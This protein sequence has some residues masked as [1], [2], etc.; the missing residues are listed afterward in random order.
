[1][2]QYG[3]KFDSFI[4][5]RSLLETSL[6]EKQ[7]EH[8]FKLLDEEYLTKIKPIAK[9][10]LQKFKDHNK[11]SFGLDSGHFV[12]FD[13]EDYNCKL[14]TFDN[15]AYRQQ[16]K[17]DKEILQLFDK[18]CKDVTMYT[19]RLKQSIKTLKLKGLKVEV[20]E[21]EEWTPFSEYQKNMRYWFKQEGRMPSNS[22][23]ILLTINGKVGNSLTPSVDAVKDSDTKKYM[24]LYIQF[25][26]FIKNPSKIIG[27]FDPTYIADICKIC[28]ISSSKL[29]EIVSKNMKS[30]GYTFTLD[31]E[32]FND[33][34]WAKSMS[35]RLGDCYELWY[36]NAD[37]LVYSLSKKKLYWVN[38]EHDE[39]EE[40]YNNYPYDSKEFG[41]I[42]YDNKEDEKN[43]IK[44]LFKKIDKEKKF[45]I[46]N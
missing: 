33:P 15:Y 32:Y 8:L 17:S 3:H 21:S 14:V 6:Q 26:N 13:S 1:M 18:F 34:D 44:D 11:N 45:N 41:E 31:P 42:L 24:D 37:T 28:G 7:R 39:C 20:V 23:S 25:A 5:N 30:N 9:K 2:G 43:S 35:D 12:S 46:L 10:E 16:S 4:I 36:D 40:F 19:N 38:Y 29:N 22:V 27:N